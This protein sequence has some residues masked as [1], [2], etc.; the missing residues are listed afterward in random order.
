MCHSFSLYLFFSFLYE[1]LSSTSF[2]K[3]LKLCFQASKWAA[4]ICVPLLKRVSST[5]A[6]DERLKTKLEENLFLFESYFFFRFWTTIAQNT[7]E[8][9]TRRSSKSRNC[10][11]PSGGWHLGCHSF[12]FKLEIM[13]NIFWEKWL[14]F[15]FFPRKFIIFADI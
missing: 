2:G 5:F 10:P 11:M 3:V 13:K 8:S 7:S 14:H 9:S 12:P 4:P 15:N 6:M 1:M